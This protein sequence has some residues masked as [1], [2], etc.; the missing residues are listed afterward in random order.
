MKRNTLTRLGVLSA[1]MGM[2]LGSGAWAAESASHT[3]NV[4][5]SEINEITVAQDAVALTIDGD[6]ETI[7]LNRVETNTSSWG[8]FT[9]RPTTDQMKVSAKI[10]LPLATGLTLKVAAEAPSN[11]TSADEVALGTSD[12]AVVTGIFAVDQLAG[13]PLNLTYKLYA[14]KDA[15]PA[16]V[17]AVTVTYTIADNGGGT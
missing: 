1:A 6:S 3:V 7:G 10:D 13:N 12:V 9:N 5:V 11:G 2:V 17:D 4:T 8:V 14:T 16:I 15:A